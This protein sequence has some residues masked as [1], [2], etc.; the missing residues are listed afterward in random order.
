L[1]LALPF[2][3]EHHEG[4]QSDDA[5][6]DTQDTSQIL[7]KGAVPSIHAERIKS[8]VE[9]DDLKDGQPKGCHPQML[10]RGAE[11][12]IEPPQGI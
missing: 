8:R 5:E 11:K 7:G 6:E 4:S 10:K 9:W 1:G 3:D 2:L 12:L